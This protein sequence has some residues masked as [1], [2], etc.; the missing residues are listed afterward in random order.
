MMQTARNHPFRGFSMLGMLITMVCIVVL[1]AI[2]MN[3]LN[4]A[5]SGQKTQQAGTVRSF[6]D[7]LYLMAIYQSMLA[8]ASEN[9]GE[10]ITPSRVAGNN[11]P[12]LNTTA[13]LFSAMLMANYTVPKQLISGNEYSGHVREKTNYDFTAY[14]PVEGVYWDTSFSADLKWESNDSFAHL[15]LCG[16]RFERKWRSTMETMFPLIGNRGPK[17]GVNS[18]D[19]L[20]CG[21]DGIWRGQIV[22]GDG[23]IDFIDTATPNGLTFME[24]GQRVQ[25]N[26]FAMEDG[27]GGEDAII[28]FT[29][30]MTKEGPQLQFD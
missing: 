23:H 6:E 21:R 16:K 24:E 17:D 2:L 1:F 20:A 4:L 15:P 30:T 19:S 12:T 25:D 13:S 5:V 26:I 10:Y 27:P 8:N 9:K 28:S 22:F 14:N 29:Q 3:S 7:K 18:P 11:E